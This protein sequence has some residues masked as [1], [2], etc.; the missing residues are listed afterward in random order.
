MGDIKTLII[1]SVIALV[2]FVVGGA[3]GYII[4]WT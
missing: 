2:A 3:I 4:G 1:S